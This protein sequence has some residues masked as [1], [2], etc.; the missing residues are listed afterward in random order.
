MNIFSSKIKNLSSNI[1][2]HKIRIGQLSKALKTKIGK[3]M[4][5]R[6]KIS[7]F[8]FQENKEHEIS[9]DFAK[10]LELHTL[11]L[12]HFEIL[13][14][15][16][17]ESE[18]DLIQV[19]LSTGQVPKKQL[20]SF[21]NTQKSLT[22][23]F[24]EI[25]FSE[26]IFNFLKIEQ[27]KKAD[28]EWLKTILNLRITF[29]L[30]S[31]M[32][33][34]SYIS[35]KEYEYY[36]KLSSLSIIKKKG[37]EDSFAKQDELCIKDIKRTLELFHEGN[38]S[39]ELAK[40][41]LK[42]KNEES[43]KN[44]IKEFIFQDISSEK[45]SKTISRSL[46]LIQISL[47][48]PSKFIKA[49]LENMA[50]SLQ[51]NLSKNQISPKNCFKLWF[52]L[53][54]T[55]HGI[56]QPH[57]ILNILLDLVKLFSK[58]AMKLLTQL[59]EREFYFLA[60]EQSSQ[61]R[62][63]YIIQLLKSKK[64]PDISCNQDYYRLIDV[65]RNILQIMNIQDINLIDTDHKEQILAKFSTSGNIYASKTE[66]FKNY[67]FHI[68]SQCGAEK[69]ISQTLKSLLMLPQIHNFYKEI[70]SE[71]VKYM[72]VKKKSQTIS[73]IKFLKEL[74]KCHPFITY[75]IKEKFFETLQNLF[76]SCFDE[77]K[78]IKTNLSADIVVFASEE[79]ILEK[80]LLDILGFIKLIDHQRIYLW[81]KVKFEIK[82]QI[83]L[84]HFIKSVSK[85][86]KQAQL[87][88]R[89][90]SNEMLDF[91][92]HLPKVKEKKLEIKNEKLHSIIENEKLFR[93]EILTRILKLYSPEKGYSYEL[94]KFIIE[95]QWDVYLYRDKGQVNPYLEFGSFDIMK[96]VLRRVGR[97][98]FQEILSKRNMTYL[99]MKYKSILILIFKYF[100]EYMISQ[101][102]GRS[103][104]VSKAKNED[105]DIIYLT[106]D[107]YD[108]IEDLSREKTTNMKIKKQETKLE[109]VIDK[110]VKGLS[111]EKE[112]EIEN[113]FENEMNL[114]LENELGQLQ[115][116]HKKV[117]FKINTL[118]FSKNQNQKIN[119]SNFVI[120]SR[121]NHRKIKTR[122]GIITNKSNHAKMFKK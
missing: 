6:T 63:Q 97:K 59:L 89:L 43:F 106:N 77:D 39:E 69:D 29:Q 41:I 47:D 1:K 95:Y 80:E 121:Q 112:L 66:I 46:A 24:F 71:F 99:G 98:N 25:I 22:Q 84:L 3:I 113:D 93:M 122:I 119:S 101:G 28:H 32:K 15:N 55:K 58:S 103:H 61:E 118:K 82:S 102:E 117:D 83:G 90:D 35:E 9:F 37:R 27:E 10:L 54:L 85:N 78:Q 68:F 36:Q 44:F 16:S 114:F 8:S 49:E 88:C 60:K 4:T 30:N 11:H 107:L 50:Q 53:H 86:D 70:S 74:N 92:Y 45:Y 75:F 34:T 23:I 5:I 64:C 51:E 87:I 17:K 48:P 100:H 62:F 67:I 40:K 94:L 31:K 38:I 57:F 33:Q 13:S 104:K 108:F 105:V 120:I 110:E 72:S 21:K 91:L 14:Q 65:I 79:M 109:N 12:K 7:K 76:N 73:M 116:S 56:L 52:V 42:I 19:Y 111:K 81:W 26:S 18:H 115:D 20:T 2:K 96:N